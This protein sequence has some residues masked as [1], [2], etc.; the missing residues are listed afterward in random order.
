MSKRALASLLVFAGLAC[1][2]YVSLTRKAERNITRL[3]FAPFDRAAVDAI[4][5]TGRNPMRA[6]RK[7]GGWVLDCGHEAAAGQIEAAI[8]A[9]ARV[10]SSD[11]ATTNPARF[12]ELEVDDAGGT[13]VVLVA[14]PRT[15]ADLVVGK[16]GGAG[17]YA[18][19]GGEVFLVQKLSPATFSRPAAQ[20][21]RLRL[22]SDK[23]DDLARVEFAVGGAPPYALSKK[24]DDWQLEDPSVLPPGFR[25][26]P[27]VARDLAALLVNATAQEVA[28][29]DPGPAATGLDAKADVLAFVTKD[30]SRRELR[31]GGT[32][33]ED[34]VW[35]QVVGRKELLVLAATSTRQMRRG[36]PGLRDLSLM[37]LDKD[38][39]TRLEIA[40]G[41][42]RLV[43]EKQGA[44]W[45]VASSTRPVPEDFAFDPAQ[46]DRRLALL[47]SVRALA[48]AGPGAQLGKPTAEIL[49]SLP[50]GPAKL[51]FGAATAHEA[52]PA[53]WARGNADG[54]TYVVTKRLRDQLV[55]GLES[56]EKQPAPAGIDPSQLSN[57]PPEARDQLLRQLAAQQAGR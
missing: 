35:A 15:L 31:L 27:R 41:S 25:F 45:K 13:R 39:V 57:L 42:A 26:D 43:L 24:G 40:D 12:A 36:V 23:P 28:H 6:A 55:G 20:W 53:V 51:T 18:R 29:H 4:E 50:E 44:D 8:D 32:A 34:G 11:V 49:A 54:E 21:H 38:K 47:A 1:A 5:I 33:P 3:G 52:T 30:G 19:K 7:D 9:I 48:L 10:D 16:A 14:G 17:T 56:F 2:A 22:F 46:V 37:K